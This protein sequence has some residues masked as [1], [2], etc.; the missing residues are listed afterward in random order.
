MLAQLR[1]KFSGS[2]K[3]RKTMILDF[4][5][6]MPIVIWSQWFF[7]S[8]FSSLSNLQKRTLNLLLAFSMPPSKLCRECLLYYHSNW[9]CH[10]LQ[11]RWKLPV[12]YVKSWRTLRRY[13]SLLFKRRRCISSMGFPTLPQF[14]WKKMPSKSHRFTFCLV[15]LCCFKMKVC[16]T[17]LALIK[18]NSSGL[19]CWSYNRGYIF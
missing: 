12:C 19:S 17:V 18:R 14:R 7:C 3:Y 8:P 10:L 16:I 1:R 11:G 9:Y 13:F 6:C 15:F 2:V 5:D 4:I